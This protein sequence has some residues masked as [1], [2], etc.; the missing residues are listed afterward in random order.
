M[1]TRIDSE[2][3]IAGRGD[4]ITQGSGLGLGVAE[5]LLGGDHRLPGL[6]GWVRDLMPRLAKARW[7]QPTS[8]LPCVASVPRRMRWQHDMR[9]S[10][11][12]TLCRD[13]V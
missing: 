4:P 12:G 6:P 2:V 3:L 13:S 10:L 1:T 11:I 9:T 7:A 8:Q 5:E